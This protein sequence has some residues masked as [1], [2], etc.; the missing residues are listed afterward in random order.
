MNTCNG[1]STNNI[2][3]V[4]KI[5]RLHRFIFLIL[6]HYNIVQLNTPFVLH[7]A[8]IILSAAFKALTTNPSLRNLKSL[9]SFGKGKKNEETGI[10]MSDVS[11]D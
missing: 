2:V 3:G 7:I 6:L 11:E 9:L 10:W 4:T 1:E 5:E 8:E